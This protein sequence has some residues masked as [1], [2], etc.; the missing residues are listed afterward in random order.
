MENR[1]VIV[2]LIFLTIIFISTITFAG[3]DLTAGVTIS[4]V[5]A[6]EME[7]FGNPI[8]GVVRAVGIICSVVALMLLGIKYML[9]SVEQRAEYK[10]SFTIYIIGAVLAFGISAFAELIYNTI[11]D[12][13]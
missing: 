3:S 2:L 9:G 12:M 4:G 11:K 8:F 13:F 10:K 6:K 7:D 1:K 5:K